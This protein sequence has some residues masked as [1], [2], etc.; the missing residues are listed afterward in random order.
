MTFV[1]TQ[2]MP[3]TWETVSGSCF[4]HLVLG[5]STTSQ[6]KTHPEPNLEAEG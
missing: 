1:K 6:R 5:L 3:G 4:I 2:V